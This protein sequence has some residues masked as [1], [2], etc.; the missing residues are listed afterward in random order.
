[1]SVETKLIQVININIIFAPT[2]KSKN[3]KYVATLNI[4][5]IGELIIKKG[6]KHSIY[7]KNATPLN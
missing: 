1:M 2:L 7:K 6:L 3:D 4:N 5:K